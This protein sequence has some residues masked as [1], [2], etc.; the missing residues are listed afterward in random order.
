M[1]FEKCLRNQLNIHKVMEPRDLLKMCYQASFGA[2]HLLQDLEGVKRYFDEEFDAVEADFS[3]PLY[4][5]L[6]EKI[7]RVNMAAWKGK[8]LPG[9]WLFNMFAASASVFKDNEEGRK[10]FLTYIDEV[11]SAVKE[12]LTAFSLDV[13]EIALREYKEAGMPAVHHSQNYRDEYHPAYRIV[14]TEFIRILPV[15]ERLAALVHKKELIVIAIDGRAA[16]GKTTAAQHLKLIAGADVIQMDDFFLPLDL[17]SEE[18]M[19]EIGGNVHY[20]RFIDE[21]LPVVRNKD[22]F[23]YRRF[24]CSCMCYNGYREIGDSIIRVVEGSY[25]LHPK[26]GDYADIKVFSDVSPD[27]QMKRIVKRNGEEMAKRFESL[28]IPL[29]ERY[30]KGYHID[31]NTDVRLI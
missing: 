2:E 21:V 29:E 24:D 14:S 1:K 25:C 30:F 3:L 20:E 13:W 22:A 28:W 8:N 10:V 16:S 12:G 9:E 17:R 5:V 26:I 15:L 6:S 31:E 18:R 4:E 11:E 19:A 27:L 7:C 23:K